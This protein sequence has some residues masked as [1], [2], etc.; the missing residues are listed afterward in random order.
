M[1]SMAPADTYI[2][3]HLQEGPTVASRELL[4]AVRRDVARTNQ[5]LAVPAPGFGLRSAV[6]IGLIAAT[7]AAL[8]VVAG[9]D[10]VGPTTDTMPAASPAVSSGPTSIDYPRFSP[11]EEGQQVVLEDF[12]EPLRFVVPHFPATGGNPL[13]VSEYGQGDAGLGGTVFGVGL[14]DDVHL[15][16]DLCRPTTGALDDV[17][18]SGA[19]FDDW[20]RWSTGV[21]VRASG[22]LTGT[23]GAIR[24][25]TV[26]GDGACLDSGLLGPGQRR[27]LY[28]VPTGDDTILVT[29]GS[30]SAYDTMDQATRDLVTSLRFR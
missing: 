22:D 27:Q 16:A 25:A 19:A 6:T 13:V 1:S 2:R 7:I 9:R 17:P 28:L 15:P 18:P 29:A 12:S 26:V 5:T 21:T 3:R 8:A 10:V 30:V 14:L 20:I 11:V 24:W 4:E 23:A